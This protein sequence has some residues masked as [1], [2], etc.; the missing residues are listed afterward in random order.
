[1]IKK[2]FKNYLNRLPF[3]PNSSN[4][5]VEINESG[6][7]DQYNTGRW[8]YLDQLSELAHYSVIVGYCQHF[9]LNGKILDVGCGEGVLQQRLSILPYGHYTGIDISSVAI[10]NAQ[11]YKNKHTEFQATDALS[12]QTNER[13]NIIIFNESLYCFNDCIKVLQHY[14]SLLTDDGVFIISMH[15]QELSLKHWKRI[16]E[17]HDVID[18]VKITNQENTSWI[19]KAIRPKHDN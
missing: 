18:S 10:E 12:F 3:I 7:N 1:M 6:W 8:S 15:V 9:A 19:C 14:Q 13:Y 17:H 4:Y 5:S 11:Q 2:I 16:E